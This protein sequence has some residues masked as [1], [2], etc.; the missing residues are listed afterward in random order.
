MVLNLCAIILL[1]SLLALLVVPARFYKKNS[2]LMQ[3]FCL[4]MVFVEKFRKL[5]TLG[6]LMALIMAH[7]GAHVIMPNEPDVLVSSVLCLIFFN[8][9]CTDR[10]LRFIQ[11][12]PKSFYALGLLSLL[13]LYTPHLFSFSFLVGYVLLAAAFYPSK[14]IMKRIKDGVFVEELLKHRETIVKHYF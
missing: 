11:S 14:E 12:H 2:R 6:L 9:R 10:I 5:Y 4:R 13:L 1:V 7:Y 8:F 3:K